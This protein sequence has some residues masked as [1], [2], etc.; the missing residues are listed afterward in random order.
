MINTAIP[1]LLILIVYLIGSI[2]FGVLIAKTKGI[3]LQKT[4]SGNIGATNVLRSLGK[5]P[6]LVT[7]SGDFLKG[8]VSVMLC[9]YILGG[10]ILESI[11][12]ITVVAGHM[13]PV[14]LSFRG[15]KG[16]ATGFGVLAVYSPVS[17]LIILVI[18]VIAAFITKYSSLAAIAAF[19]SL[20]LVFIIV[21]YSLIKI[22]FAIVLAFLIILK[23]KGNLR[24]LAEGSEPKLK[25]TVS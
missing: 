3:D 9:S 19:I 11:A 25:K 22:S 1:Y 20:P 5:W 14:F 17:L 21:D 10:E 7:L 8:T 13:Y 6:A 23:H 16:V 15:G 12:G 18:W 4:G 2:P 24:R